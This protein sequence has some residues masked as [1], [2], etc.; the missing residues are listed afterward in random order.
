MARVQA[1]TTVVKGA[2]RHEI[3]ELEARPARPG[4]QTG[5]GQPEARRR[6]MVMRLQTRRVGS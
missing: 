3:A 1:L 6:L 2:T 5:S 4:G